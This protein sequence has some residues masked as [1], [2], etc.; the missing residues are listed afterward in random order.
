[1]DRSENRFGE[2]NVLKGF[3]GIERIETI[4]GNNG[5]S[6]NPARE[7]FELV[8]PGPLALGWEF[9]AV[10]GQLA[11]DSQMALALVVQAHGPMGDC[12]VGEPEGPSDRLIE[13]GKFTS[14]GLG[15]LGGD[16][17]GIRAGPEPRGAKHIDAGLKDRT[18]TAKGPIQTPGIRLVD[19]KG[20]GRIDRRNGAKALRG[21]SKRRA[22]NGQ[23]SRVSGRS[24]DHLAAL[25]RVGSHG[26][27]AKDVLA[28]LGSPDSQLA[29][30][31]CGDC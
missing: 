15:F 24:I 23:A 20:L 26:G 18:A 22:C 29:V 6:L 8:G 13:G 14:I 3:V 7:G 16:P 25:D 31:S 2:H 5:F 11:L 9:R 27:F 4:V 28:S 1:M 10:A 30:H 19:S 12:P 17:N 21:Q